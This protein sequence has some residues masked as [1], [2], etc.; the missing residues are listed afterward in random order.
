MNDSLAVE[1]FNSSFSLGVDVGSKCNHEGLLADATIR[2]LASKTPTE[3]HEQ[4]S[5]TDA[6]GN[7]CDSREVSLKVSKGSRNSGSHRYDLSFLLA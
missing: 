7:A 5:S 1:L 2:N 6:N 4:G 3:P